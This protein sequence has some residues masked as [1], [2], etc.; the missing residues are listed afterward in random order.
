MARN[1]K[2]DPSLTAAGNHQHGSDESVAPARS[3]LS[4]RLSE[5]AGDEERLRAMFDNAP[6]GIAQTDLGGRFIFVNRQYCSILGRSA[7]ELMRMRLQDLTHPDDKSGNLDSL[8]GLISETQSTVIEKPYLRPDGTEIWVNHGISFVKDRQGK[9][10]FAVAVVQDI[11]SRKRSEEDLR[12][13]EET[14][15]QHAEELEQQ[16]IASGRLVSL[17]ELT[18]SM[19]HEFNNPLGI[20]LGF[21]EDLMSDMDS[22]DP[23]FRS[24]QIIDE[25]ARRCEKIVKDLLEFARPRSAD[26][27]R[28]DVAEVIKKTME[29]ISSRV[30]KQKVEAISDMA[31]ELPPIHAD[32]QQL[33]QVL[34]NLCLNALDAMPD[35]GKLTISARKESA[36]QL[37]ITVTDTGFG[38]DH[39]TRSKIFK[40]FFTAKKRKGLGLGLPISERIVKSHGGTVQVASEP[41]QGATF[42]IRLPV[43]NTATREPSPAS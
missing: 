34:A 18:A 39:E 40:P 29:M 43:K 22:G 6:V 30:F 28:T 38:M 19:A 5:G 32:A 26:F 37:T 13:R 10:R 33:Q 4:R 17:G 16:L 36:D 41:N 15:R 1:D 2:F 23:N 42:T 31:P 11:T 12:R 8:E 3:R 20:I 9:P 7:N 21:A 14:F 24:L 27:T 25:E 35:G